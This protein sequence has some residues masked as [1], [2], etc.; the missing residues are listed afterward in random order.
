MTT[1]L[2]LPLEATERPTARFAQILVQDLTL[3]VVC[4]DAAGRVVD[5]NPAAESILGVSLGEMLGRA[6]D[7]PAWMAVD[8]RGAPLPAESHPAMVALRT[9]HRS[10]GFLMSVFHPRLKEPRWLRVDAVP[11]PGGADGVGTSSRCWPT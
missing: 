10:R 4:H 7:D 2:P 1:P 11:V 3:G 5:A 9:G 8:E 6:P